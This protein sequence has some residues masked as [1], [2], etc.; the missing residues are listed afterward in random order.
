MR[1]SM[2]RPS[3]HDCG[4]GSADPSAAAHVKHDAAECRSIAMAYV[5]WQHFSRTYELEQAIET[6][7]IFPE[8]DKPFTGKG[9]NCS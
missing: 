4:C 2:R 5:P 3:A 1:G 9:G 8:L 6:G 7:T